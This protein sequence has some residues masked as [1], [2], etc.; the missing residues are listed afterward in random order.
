MLATAELIRN[1]GIPLEEISVGSTP[2]LILCDE[3]LD[4]ITEIRP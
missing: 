3:I 4:G 1:E 2:S